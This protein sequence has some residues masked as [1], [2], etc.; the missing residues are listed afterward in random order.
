MYK[1]Y[2]SETEFAATHEPTVQLVYPGRSL[3]KQAADFSPHHNTDIDEYLASVRPEEGYSYLLILALGSS[4]IYG[5]NRN[6]DW[7]DKDELEETYR[8]FEE[9]P[10]YL[11]RHHQ[12]KDPKNA[13]GKVVKSFWNPMMRRVEIIV[14]ME[15]SKA[16]DIVE[17]L[18]AGV[19]VATSMGC[20]VKFDICSECGNK[21]KTRSEYC[22][23]LRHQ[24]RH[25]HDDGRQIYAIND[26]PSFFDISLVFRPADRTS[27]VLR[28]IAGEAEPSTTFAERNAATLGEIH[29]KISAIGKLSDINKI[30]RGIPV[31]MKVNGVNRDLIE[32]YRDDRLPS[33]L[34]DCPQL[35]GETLDELSNHP[36]ITVI[37]VLRDNGY[38]MTTPEI[39]KTLLS[40]R[41][42]GRPSDV[43]ETFG[44]IMAMIMPYILELLRN[45]EDVVDDITTNHPEFQE[46]SEDYYKVS[47]LL[48]TLPLERN[49]SDTSL[50]KK[51]ASLNSGS[52]ISWGET[53]RAWKELSSLDGPARHETVKVVLPNGNVMVIP[54][55]EVL[56][57]VI[58]DYCKAPVISLPLS[59][60]AFAAGLISGAILPDNS[61]I[62]GERQRDSRLLNL[63]GMHGR[64]MKSSSYSPLSMSGVIATVGLDAC[65]ANGCTVG[66][67]LMHLK[68][69]SISSLYI[70]TERF[71][72][73]LKRDLKI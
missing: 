7:F 48:D 14:R 9:N 11:Y 34:S 38:S 35:P 49:F 22:D 13:A 33:L 59:G 24:M 27:Y 36:T 32:K 73:S 68:E 20:K 61:D 67:E 45:R 57:S 18:L 54:R 55:E 29:E 53:M 4:D 58:S 46:D 23:H 1:R 69:A 63:R 28:K 43:P 40:K 50:M 21:A 56:H 44:R 47:E 12:N 64:M 6:G 10:A 72:R 37:K 31:R 5:C 2:E 62:V 52:D 71:I 41:Y 26:S 30:V 51:T 15:N 60:T 19:P 25:I 66:E 16:P 70:G 42:G 39:T 3:I 65:L 17:K 8:S